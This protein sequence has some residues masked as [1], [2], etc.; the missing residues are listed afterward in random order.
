M[1]RVAAMLEHIIV[2]LEESKRLQLNQPQEYAD[3]LIVIA[4]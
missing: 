2:S 4:Q 3:A 1:R